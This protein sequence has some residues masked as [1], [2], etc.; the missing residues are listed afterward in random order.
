M[1][2]GTY[3]N[4]LTVNTVEWSLRKHVIKKERQESMNRMANHPHEM[5]QKTGRADLREPMFENRGIAA[6]H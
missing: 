4:C 3:R 5:P 6:C 2:H 1:S